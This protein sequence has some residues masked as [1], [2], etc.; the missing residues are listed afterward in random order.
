LNSSQAAYPIEVCYPRLKRPELTEQE[1]IELGKRFRDICCEDEKNFKI[2]IFQMDQQVYD[3]KDMKERSFKSILSYAVKAESKISNPKFALLSIAAYNEY[4]ASPKTKIELLIEYKKL[5]GRD[6]DEMQMSEL[7]EMG[8]LIEKIEKPTGG[9]DDEKNNDTIYVLTDKGKQVIAGSVNLFSAL[10]YHY[11]DKKRDVE[12]KTDTSTAV[13]VEIKTAEE[14]PELIFTHLIGNVSDK[15]KSRNDNL[16][17]NK[18]KPDSN[19][20]NKKE[21]QLSHQPPFAFIVT[22]SKTVGVLS[23]ID[24]LD[25][26][27]DRLRNKSM[28]EV[29]IIND[30]EMI[31]SMNLD[32]LKIP[33]LRVLSKPELIDLV[34]KEK[35]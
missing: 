31:K 8:L 23:K 14:D 12:V 32:E 7:M 19:Q 15:S 35:L 3:S 21:Y 5:W 10:L 17:K 30:G 25:I 1:I 34:E 2:P 11:Y 22:G 27:I 20:Q 13:N 33:G 4:F 29:I 26:V 16:S 28:D 24:A 9:N 6:L 18:I